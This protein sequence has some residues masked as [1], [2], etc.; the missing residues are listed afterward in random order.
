MS[1][2]NSSSNSNFNPY[3]TISVNGQNKASVAYTPYG[4]FST[5]NMTPAQKEAYNYAQNEFAKNLSQINVFSDD[6]QKDFDNQVQNFIDSGAQDIQDIYEPMIREMQNDIASRF[7]NLDNSIFMDNLNS[8]E[9]KRAQAVS[10]LAQDAQLYR[11][12]LINNELNNRYQFL[13]YLNNY[14]QQTE[15]NI[16]STLNQATNSLNGANSYYTKQ[17]ANNNLSGLS[18]INDALS[19]SLGLFMS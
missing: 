7:G 2:L 19:T 5:Y 17:S 15:N 12:D 11:Q 10:D 1:K 16:L 13:D 18:N 8:I 14:Q 4:S 6:I 9:D 3:S